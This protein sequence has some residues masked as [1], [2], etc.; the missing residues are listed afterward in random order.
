MKGQ[1]LILMRLN[2][3]IIL[4]LLSLITPLI[5]GNEITYVSPIPS[6]IFHPAQ[7]QL[8]IRFKDLKPD[9]LANLDSFIYIDGEKSGTVTG[10][11]VLS[12][13]GKTI[14]YKPDR[15]F[16]AG[17]KVMVHL[18]PILTG[19]QQAFLDTSY[20]FIISP[21]ADS[22][23]PKA[24]TDEQPQSVPEKP[25]KPTDTLPIIRNGISIP[26]D[27]PWVDITINDNP[28]TGLIFIN[29]WGGAQYIMIL[30]NFGNPLWY[31][32]VPDRRRDFKVQKDGR[33]TMLV[34]QGY[35]G[36]SHIA[37]DSTYAIVDT[38]FYPAGY[39]IDEH[40]LQV[41]PGGNYFLIMADRQ[42]VDMSELVEG[43]NPKASILGSHFAEMDAND[44]CIFLWRSWDHYNI[45]DA[46]NEDL[47]ASFI[48]YVHMNAIEIDHDGNIL[49]SSRFQSEVSKIN[50]ETGA[51][52]WRL[53]GVNNQF[54]WVN[55]EHKISYQH[56]IR[57]LA[58]GHY[59]VFDNGNR[60]SPVF[61]RALELEIDTLN[62]TV[63]KVWEFRED[64]DI[65]SKYMGNTQR[66][67]NGN[68]LINWAIRD[69]PKLT[70]VRPDG[71]KAF[72]MDFAKGYECYRVFR[73]P[74]KGKAATPYLLAESLSDR[75]TLLFNQFGY[76]DVLRYNI[77]AGPTSAPDQ[78]IA[79]ATEPY[80]HLFN[81]PGQQYYYFRVTSVNG[82]AQE[83]N[84]SNEVKI[85]R[86]AIP[87][88]ENLVVNGDFSSG[89]D[90]W[91]LNVDT[92][93]AIASWTLDSAEVLHLQISDGGSLSS[94]IQVSYP[95]IRL[96]NEHTYIF[97]FDAYASK[98]RVI[99]AEVT[100]GSPPYESYSRIGYTWLTDKIQHHSH[101]FVMTHPSDFTAN[102]VFNVGGASDDV[103]IDNVSLKEV[104]TTGE[105]DDPANPPD[106]ALYANYPNPF[107]PQTTIRFSLAQRSRVILTVFNTLGEKV[108]TLA[109]RP[110]AAGE[111]QIRFDATGLS[112]GLYFYHMSARS[113][114]KL[115]NFT[116]FRKMILIR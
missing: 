105:R 84:F 61:S 103:F 75:V 56:D 2:T 5:S 7:T 55:D 72:E 104:V 79:T 35:G 23:I 63:T 71:S 38:F 28:D 94:Q 1:K 18:T 41:L 49:I 67:P 53:G 74:W 26:S 77:Y 51:F 88:G 50:R 13:D 101:Q 108:A 107:N 69:E 24:V 80:I 60:R 21:T 76:P 39:S 48:E 92:A 87:S 34:R 37:L 19:Y 10:R 17:E 90:F 114:S 66:L 83:S 36:G 16:L 70:E 64:P 62:M 8:I 44:N 59:T 40:E 27:F 82:E 20:Y 78:I 106:Y 99:E 54:E 9:Q 43:G 95:N 15:L 97:E 45:A 109:D 25:A 11:I 98:G 96:E 3:I 100:M 115:Q 33:L 73:F 42:E 46:I 93:N 22:E 68:T 32:K 14:I 86:N 29:N 89:F 85:Y 111:H 6:S 113:V 65:Y 12:S 110:Y 47:T 102:I 4:A 58:N 30:D 57:V 116:D 31:Q 81:I 91:N 52:I 112:S